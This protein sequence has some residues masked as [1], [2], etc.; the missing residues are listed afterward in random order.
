LVHSPGAAVDVSW[1]DT[2]AEGEHRSL[3]PYSAFA[4]QRGGKGHAFLASART[5]LRATCALLRRLSQ[6]PPKIEAVT[7][8]NFGIGSIRGREHSAGLNLHFTK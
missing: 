6:M 7:I 8:E 5:R 3:D 2:K 4:G 1:H